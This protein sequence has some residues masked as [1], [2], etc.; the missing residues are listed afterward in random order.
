MVK[1][2][3][4]KMARILIIENEELLAQ[5]LARMLELGGHEVLVATNAANGVAQGVAVR[6]DLIIA[7][8]MLGGRLHGG[9]VAALIADACPRVKTIIITGYIGIASQVRGSDNR[10]DEVIEKPFHTEQMLAA[11]R[12]L[13]SKTQF[14]AAERRRA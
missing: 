8:W 5:T 9:E 4:E 1:L 11:V 14:S 3:Y 2:R 7:D 10:I 13:L 6:P 12:R